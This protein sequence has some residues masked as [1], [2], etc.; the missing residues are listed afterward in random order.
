MEQQI[1]D[2]IKKF[3]TIAAKNGDRFAYKTEMEIQKGALL[4]NFVITETQEN[5]VITAQKGTTL[6]EA[7]KLADEGLAEALKPWGYSV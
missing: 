3:N 6:L 1:A 2:F 5:A 7:L 4:Y